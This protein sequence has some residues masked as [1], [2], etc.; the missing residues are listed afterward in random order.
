MRKVF[1]D[2]KDYD[3][4][5]FFLLYGTYG[6]RAVECV[7]LK[8]IQLETIKKT[9]KK[10]IK[11]LGN[12]WVVIKADCSVTKKPQQVRMGKGKGVHNY[13]VAIVK[14]GTILIEV[15]GR[16]LTE[17]LAIHA[18]KVASKK[19]PIKTEVFSYQQ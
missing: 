17:K 14:K 11:K 12:V 2:E 10:I 15:G 8:E 5:R 16:N 13:F 3:Y 9:I 7:R 1:V 18:L 6:L 19:L 4:K